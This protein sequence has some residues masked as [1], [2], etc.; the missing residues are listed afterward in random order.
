ML[1]KFRA[2]VDDVEFNGLDEVRQRPG[3]HDELLKGETRGQRSIFLNRAWKAIDEI[4]SDG[5]LDLVE[6]LGGQ[7]P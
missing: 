1:M 6:G 3:C 4:K 2:W 5:T 7:S